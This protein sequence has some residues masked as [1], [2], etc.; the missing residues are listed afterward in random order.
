MTHI[1]D[2]LGGFQQ[3]LNMSHDLVIEVSANADTLRQLVDDPIFLQV[4]GK[5]GVSL[6]VHLQANPFM[7]FEIKVNGQPVALSV[8]GNEVV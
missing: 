8:G 7:G 5:S 6:S 1:Q 3:E 4:S 2:W